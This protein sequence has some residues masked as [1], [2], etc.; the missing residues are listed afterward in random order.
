MT[1]CTLVALPLAA[2]CE[3]FALYGDTSQLWSVL[4]SPTQQWG[5]NQYKEQQGDP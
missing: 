3:A 2:C 4:L 5:P 1:G